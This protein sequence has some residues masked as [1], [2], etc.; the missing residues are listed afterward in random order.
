MRLFRASQFSRGF[1]FVR[2]LNCWNEPSKLSMS[3]GSG[4]R[5]KPRTYL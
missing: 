4:W 1:E 3:T 2:H 5:K